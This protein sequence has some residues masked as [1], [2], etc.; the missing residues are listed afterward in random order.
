MN[1]DYTRFAGVC[2]TPS[3]LGLC[4]LRWNKC[5]IAASGIIVPVARLAVCRRA[6][7]LGVA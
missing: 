1:V 3:E 5:N 7:V 2:D 6:F 4:T